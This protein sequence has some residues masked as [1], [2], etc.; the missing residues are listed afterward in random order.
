[1]RHIKVKTNGDVLDLVEQDF[2]LW[3]FKW[4][5]QITRPGLIII[6][7]TI[8]GTFLEVGEAVTLDY[9][10]LLREKKEQWRSSK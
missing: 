3:K 1:M 2:I 8:V 7:P 5:T 9:N 10:T 6:D 4:E